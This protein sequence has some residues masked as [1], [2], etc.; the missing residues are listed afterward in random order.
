M[1]LRMLAQYA[2]MLKRPLG[3]VFLS[4]SAIPPASVFVRVTDGLRYTGHWRPAAILQAGI[5]F[6]MAPNRLCWVDRHS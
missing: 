2:V 1:G 5:C 3:H 6:L 4:E